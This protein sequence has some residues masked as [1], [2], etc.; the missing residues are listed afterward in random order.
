MIHVGAVPERKQEALLL[1]ERFGWCFQPDA[2]ETPH[3]D[4][5]L[6][7]A[8][9]ALYWHP[10]TSL[11]FKPFCV[12]HSTPAL[13][14][15]LSQWHRDPLIKALGRPEHLDSKALDLTLGFGTDAL[16]LAASGYHVHAYEQHPLV[17]A[18]AQDGLRR[19]QHHPLLAPW[20]ARLHITHSPAPDPLPDTEAV[21][22]DPMFMHPRKTKTHKAM[23]CL[24]RLIQDQPDPAA[25]LQRACLSA[26]RRVVVKRTRHAPAL[27]QPEHTFT[28]PSCCFDRYAGL[29]RT[30]VA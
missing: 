12:D 18:L 23:A 14:R 11:R 21:F 19:A 7:H 2:C 1:C 15:R 25:L 8:A 9:D 27:A 30:T 24:Q 4:D 29:L 22:L 20:V 26:S 17:F 6:H 16:L 13:L 3:S 10:P 28:H 5:R